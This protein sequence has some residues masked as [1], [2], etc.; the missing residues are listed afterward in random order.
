MRSEFLAFS[1]PWITEAEIDAV[2][3]TLR[4]DWITTGPKVREFEQRFAEYIGTSA[5]HGVSS[6][7][8]AL[9][10][11]LAAI[12][13]GRGDAVFAPT[14]TFAATTNVVDHLGATPVLCDV[15]RDSLNL[16]PNSLRTQIERV[17]AEGE[18]TPKAVTPVHYAGQPCDMDEIVA[19]AAEYGLPIVEDA[20]HSLPAEYQGRMI[21]ADRSDDPVPRLAAFSFYATKNLTTAEGGMLTGPEELIDEAR[22]WSL[23]G[24]SRDAWKRYGSGGSWFYEVVRPGFKCNMTD[25]AAAIG[26]VQLDRLEGFQ[27][28]RREVAA[29]YADGLGD[30]PLDLPTAA[31]DRSSAWHLYPIRLREGGAEARQ[32]LIEHMGDQK[33]GTSVHF[34]PIHLHPWYRDTFGYQSEDFPVAFAE[35]QRLVSLPMHPRLSDEDVDDVITAVRK[36]IES[37]NSA[38]A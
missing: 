26:L 36:G 13:V 27:E 14:M 1:P 32:A 35:Y 23:H 17:L 16:D 37:G 2:V 15:Q 25:I 33:I 29:A 9:Q 20:A 31:T 34:I 21:G 38:V 19:V 22:L 11:A 12:G 8:D 10:I 7:T 24:M 18:L 28:R 30:L 4:S 3:D 6:C 5:A